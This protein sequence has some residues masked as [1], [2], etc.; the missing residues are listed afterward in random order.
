MNT[1]NRPR[2]LRALITLG[3]VLA[4]A[5]VVT[6]SNTPV[7][8]NSGPDLEVVSLTTTNTSPMEG[9]SFA[10]DATV[11]NDGD[12][13]SAATT[14][15]YYQST[16]ATISSA[17]T[18]VGTDAVGTL[19]AG[20]TSPG[21]SPWGNFVV[22]YAPSPAGTYYY[23]AC[24]DAVTGESDTTN[25]C[26]A[27]VT[28]E[29][30]A[31]TTFPDLQVGQPTVTDS[32]VVAGGLFRLTITVTNI[33]D[34]GSG[35]TTLRYY[36]S[37]DATISSADTQVGTDGIRSLGGTSFVS[38]DVTAP[39]T[40]GTYYYGACVDAVRLESDTTNNCS[41]SVTVEVVEA[42]TS[43]DL[44]VG[45]PTVTDSTVVAGGSFTLSATVSNAGAGAS[46]ATT[47]RYYLRNYQLTDG[48]ISNPK[49]QVGTDEVG[50]LAASETSAE[51]ISL[52]ARSKAG[53]YDYGVCVDAVPLELDTTNNCSGVVVE[54]EEAPAFPDLTVVS[55]T[56][57][58]STLV[59]GETFT[60]S[61]TVA[62]IGDADSSAATTL[63]F[64]RST[65]AT[66]GAG[67]QVGGIGMG[68]LAASG[69]NEES[70]ELYAPSTAGTYYYGAC[71]NSVPDE[72]DTTN[73]CSASVT[74]EVEAT[75]TFP[76]LQVGQPTVTDSTVVAGGLFRLT[77]TVTN[78][79][80]RGSGATTL[81]YYQSTDATISSADTQ[82]GT[83]GI[84]SLGGTSFVSADVTA[85]LTGGTYY[86]GACVDA[87]PVESDTT[88]NCSPS[89]TVEV[90]EATTSPD[91][92]VGHPTVTDS[93]AVAG[94]S[95]TLSATVSNAGAGASE[96]TTL[97]YY[98]RNYQL[99]DGTISNPKSQVGTDEVGTLAA[100]ETSAES[101]SLTAPSKA[102]TYYYGVCVDVVPLES[103]TTNN[104]S[105]SVPVE[106]EEAPAFP[107]LTVVSPTVTDSTLVV[108]ETFTLSVT[109]ANIGDADSSAATTLRFL[110]S[111]N[112]TPGAGTLVGSIGMGYLAASGT[113]EESIE[114]Y[115]PSTAGTYY[116]GAC[117]DSVTDEPDT[118]NNC[119]GYVEVTVTNNLATGAPTISGTAQ[120]GQT[121]TASTSG[122][123]DTDGLDNVSYSYQWLADDTAIEG[124]T[125]STY[126]VQSSD[127]GKVI[128]VQVTFTDDAGHEETLTSAAT[129][130]TLTATREELPTEETEE[131]T[132]QRLRVQ[133]D[134]NENGAIDRDEVVTA[135]S[136]YLFDELITRDEV[137]AVI[138]MYLFG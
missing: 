28:V 78:I 44:Q 15:R 9:G 111:T 92:Q 1:A 43:P 75:T 70:I 27:S 24:V 99:T 7:H 90:V 102:G 36:Q 106:V 3:V 130:E 132:E 34:R 38:A 123:A 68:Y 58:D 96:A 127:D 71:V 6:T 42:T 64:L 120:V 23:G 2:I 114:L 107:D 77:I 19:A 47:L 16:D 59:V 108:G 103:D 32:T 97:R 11:S 72:S 93:T 100:S 66:P 22:L 110:R 60:L 119:S 52:T 118:P 49:S 84:R 51:S 41:A 5:A 30:E 50:T 61:V 105:G 135:I 115:A 4:L 17:D 31:T 138:N 37:T 45:R 55:P 20:G 117:V 65:N 81:R 124:A 8:A 109:V 137:L 54:V 39:L 21:G 116:Y 67:T 29:V 122:I 131:E 101:I 121:L 73:N 91:L 46:E 14:L 13:E 112:A 53:T 33:G 74:V 125:S 35:A 98:L 136:D 57:T 129:T 76:D 10:L 133:Y 18:E 95:F 104:C 12:G 94:G 80:D 89:V 26:S 85:P 62:N 40:G 83:D 87:V 82:V 69:T 113:N 63:R 88:N 128:K 126:T 48:T 79:G 86:Y 134:A 56:V 25:N